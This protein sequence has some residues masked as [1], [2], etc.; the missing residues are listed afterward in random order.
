MSPKVSPRLDWPLGQVK[1]GTCKP[2]RMMCISPDV[3]CL[4]GTRWLTYFCVVS[5]HW[6][7]SGKQGYGSFFVY[8]FLHVSDYS[9][10]HLSWRK[11]YSLDK[12]FIAQTRNDNCFVCH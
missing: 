12:Y 4:C 2:S 3:V 5:I 9:R 10:H 11:S 8:T 7:V 1:L 6:K